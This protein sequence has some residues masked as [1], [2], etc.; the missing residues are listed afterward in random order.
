MSPSAKM[1]TNPRPRSGRQRG[2]TLIELL[3]VIA[4]IAILA[5]LLLPALAG[6]KQ[7]G[8]AIVCASNVRQCGLAQAIYADDFD[9]KMPYAGM[10]SSPT[11]QWSWD[12]LV[13]SYM[14]IRQTQAEFDSFVASNVAAVVWCPADKVHRNPAFVALGAKPRTYAMPT[15][16]MIALNPN[17]ANP[18]VAARDW[19][20]GPNNGTGMGLHWDM[21]G[22]NGTPNLI[23]PGS[24]WTPSDPAPPNIAPRSQ[25]AIRKSTL[26]KPE[27]IINLTERISPDNVAGQ[28]QYVIGGSLGLISMRTVI[29]SPITHLES[30]VLETYNITLTFTSVLQYHGGTMVYQMADGHVER[31]KPEATL[32]AATNPDL[33]VGMWT[34]RP[35]D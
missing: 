9:D 26:I 5:G 19:P 16:N 13:S 30:R 18:P 11:T 31:L 29:N 34:L 21:G 15:H 12:D 14:G 17:G 20:P 6:A 7:R 35:D 3:V 1:K 22:L 25:L 27:G 10:R 33:Q 2:F 32:G 8:R 23:F 28:A 24:N 4:I